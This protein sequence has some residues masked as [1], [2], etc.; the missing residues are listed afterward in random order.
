MEVRPCAL[1]ALFSNAPCFAAGG[2]DGRL[3][4]L[5]FPLGFFFAALGLSFCLEESRLLRAL[6]HL[7]IDRLID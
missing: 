5:S 2:A 3:L 6:V 4:V 1:P 7:L